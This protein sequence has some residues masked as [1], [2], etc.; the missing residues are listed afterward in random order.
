MSDREKVEETPMTE[1]GDVEVE[2]LDDNQL[3][4]A[5]GGQNDINGFQCYC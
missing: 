2:E 4:E 3:E 1:V 5:S